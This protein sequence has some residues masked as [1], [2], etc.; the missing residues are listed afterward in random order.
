MFNRLSWV[1]LHQAESRA[2]LWSIQGKPPQMWYSFLLITLMLSLISLVMWQ[3]FSLKR[4][5]Q[6][7]A[8]RFTRKS[9]WFQFVAQREYLRYRWRSRSTQT[10][11]SPG[12][13]WVAP[14][15]RRGEFYRAELLS[16]IP[17]SRYDKQSRKMANPIFSLKG[18]N[19]RPSDAQRMD[20]PSL[21]QSGSLI[22][23]SAAVTVRIKNSSVQ[24]FGYF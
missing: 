4:S 22:Q 5:S 15:L 11:P 2:Y 14:P 24:I 6:F 8:V 9:R 13:C 20:R 7:L 16:N 10:R 18:C 1:F 12:C 17:R 3:K 21:S 23:A 19:L